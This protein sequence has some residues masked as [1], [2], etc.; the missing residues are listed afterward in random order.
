MRRYRKIC[1]EG[2]YTPAVHGLWDFI[3]DPSVYMCVK[4]LY[5]IEHRSLCIDFITR[6]LVFFVS[7]GKL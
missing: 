3:R 1:I 2:M 5:L 4:F 7:I 6:W